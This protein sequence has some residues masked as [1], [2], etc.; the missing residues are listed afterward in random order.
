MWGPMEVLLELEWET[1]LIKASDS[2]HKSKPLHQDD[3]GKQKELPRKS[4]WDFI[5]NRS[6]S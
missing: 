3:C 6:K 2:A 4:Y 1:I 5:R